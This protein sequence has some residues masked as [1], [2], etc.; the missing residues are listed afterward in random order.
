MNH[1]IELP[2]LVP[3]FQPIVN[4]SSGLI[5]GYELLGRYRQANRISSLGPFFHD[6]L[7]REDEKK[8]VDRHIRRL[9]MQ[10][11]L[12]HAAGDEYVKLFININPAWI[13][14]Y[15]EQIRKMQTLHLIDELGF[16]PRQLVVEITEQ[17]IATT[18]IHYLNRLI[19]Q[20]RERG[21]QIAIDDFSLLDIDRLLL[22]KPEILKID[23]ML[24]THAL[25][26]RE[27]RCFLIHISNLCLELGIALVYEGIE[28]VFEVELALDCGATMLQGYLLAKPSAELASVD[29]FQEQIKSYMQDMTN[30]KQRYYKAQIKLQLEIRQW[31]M[32][33]LSDKMLS[34]GQPDDCIV[35][36]LP[37][38]PTGCFRVYI[39]NESGVQLSANF[40]RDPQQ[41]FQ[42]NQA[43]C[44]YNWSARPFFVENIV[45]VQAIS[46]GLLSRPYMDRNRRFQTVTFTCQ[47]NPDWYLFMDFMLA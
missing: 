9:G 47:L 29:S 35:E 31:S 2:D 3:H 28:Q 4:L 12:A 26:N 25:A 15:R 42:S 18:D 1:Q 43:M 45:R 30:S 24:L 13:L 5:Y 6:T 37:D 19:D 27:Y 32:I 34:F 16:N 36:F 38:I 33:R 17:A 10:H 20:Y 7:I 23:K 39:C 14:E 21:L 8:S 22:I 40:E 44:G 41:V 11:V 46:T